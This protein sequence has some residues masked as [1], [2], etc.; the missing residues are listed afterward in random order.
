MRT[1]RIRELH[2]LLQKEHEIGYV[3]RIKDM[4][5]FKEGMALIG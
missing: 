4:V 2:R 1:S 5:H 3:I